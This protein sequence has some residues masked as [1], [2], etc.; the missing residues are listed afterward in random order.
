MIAME[1]HSLVPP[2]VLWLMD[3]PARVGAVLMETTT[4]FQVSSITPLEISTGT[5]VPASRIK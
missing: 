5:G 1:T 4:V 2:Y 3:R